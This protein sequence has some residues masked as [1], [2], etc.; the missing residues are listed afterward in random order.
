[1]V[2]TQHFCLRWNNYQSSITSA[3]ENLRDDE[4]FVDVTLACEGKSLKAHRVVLS[5]CSPYFRELLKSTPCAHPVIVLQDVAFADLHALVEFIYHGEVNVHQRSLTSFLKTAEVLRVSGLTQQAEERDELGSAGAGITAPRNLA[6]AYPEK[7]EDARFPSPIT[8]SP[9]GSALAANG[10]GAAAALLRRP[11]VRRDSEQAGLGGE[12]DLSM[13][14]KRAKLNNDEVTHNSNVVAAAAA[15]MLQQAAVVAAAAAA[16]QQTSPEDFSP[17]SRRGGVEMLENNHQHNPDLDRKSPKDDL[18]LAKQETGDHLGP[19]VDVDN[20]DSMEGKAPSSIASDQ[21]ETDGST[22][23]GPPGHFNMQEKLH[24]LFSASS[25]GQPFN[26]NLPVSRQALSEAASLSSLANA[27]GLNQSL[28]ELGLSPG[29]VL[30]MRGLGYRCEPCGKNLTSPQRLRRHIQNVHAKPIKP[31]VCN[32]C[33]KVYST[34]NS[35][36]NHKSIYHRALQR[37]TLSSANEFAPAQSPQ[38]K[39]EA[40]APVVGATATAADFSAS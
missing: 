27:A 3:F 36:R 30:P 15:S 20:D 1:M 25:P 17:K 34:L 38:W 32:I 8:A 16:S 31:P 9:V 2:D 4:D 40:A 37:R 18:L 7:L 14:S 24:S 35:L 29:F 28:P 10:N 11:P 22:Q 13:L 5:A 21:A 39:R 19:N 6:S 33:N 26:F 12:Y 23:G